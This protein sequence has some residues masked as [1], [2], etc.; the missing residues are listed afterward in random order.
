[1]S[2]EESRLVREAGD[3]ITRIA[4]QQL[5]DGK[6]DKA[7][8]MEGAGILFLPL[9]LA[10]VGVVGRVLTSLDLDGP[11]VVFIGGPVLIGL[12]LLVAHLSRRR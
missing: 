2:D 5:L 7:D 8:A 12:V 4:R 6:L 9:V 3:A 1:M 11:A 10:V